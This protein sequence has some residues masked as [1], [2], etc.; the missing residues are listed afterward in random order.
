MLMSLEVA[1]QIVEE[2]IPFHK[3][4]GVEMIE[5][6]E[7]YCKLKVPFREEV[8]GDPRFKRWHGG[9]IASG[10][11]AAG[12]LVAMTTLKTPEDKVTTI[13]IRVDYLRGTGPSDLIVIGELVRSGN[14]VIATKM[15]AWQENGE[16]LVAESRAMFSVYRME[17]G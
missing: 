14:R 7:G 10:M 2:F 5:L 15:Q 16:K 1:K 17:K 12:G 9:V 3:F 8:I 4:L 11:D 6:R 13:D